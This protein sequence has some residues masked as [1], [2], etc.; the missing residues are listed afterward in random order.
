[1]GLPGLAFELETGWVGGLV[2]KK[3]RKKERKIVVEGWVE[4]GKRG[5]PFYLLLKFLDL[6]EVG[7]V[8][9]VWLWRLRRGFCVFL[10]RKLRMLAF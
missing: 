2:R 1:M 6:N 3:E 5:I 7:H 4:I 8:L 10:Y 9:R